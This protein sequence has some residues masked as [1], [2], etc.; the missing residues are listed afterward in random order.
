MPTDT[1]N[2]AEPRRPEVPQHSSGASND[3]HGDSGG[4]NSDDEKTVC[5]GDFPDDVSEAE[6]EATLIGDQDPTPVSSGQQGPTTASS[7]QDRNQ[8]EQTLDDAMSR[9][10]GSLMDHLRRQDGQRG[11]QG[12]S[13]EDPSPYTQHTISWTTPARTAPKQVVHTFIFPAAAVAA[14]QCRSG[15]TRLGRGWRMRSKRV[16]GRGQAL[17]LSVSKEWVYVPMGNV[18]LRLH[19]DIC[20]CKNQSQRE[21]DFYIRINCCATASG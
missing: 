10:F 13:S 1:E 3:G 16:G 4:E 14:R 18:R 6:S 20:A 7:V 11:A 21:L 5:D 9:A 15:E 17:T 8:V 2:Q 19:C 12:A